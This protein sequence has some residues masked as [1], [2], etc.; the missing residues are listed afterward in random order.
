[1]RHSPGRVVEI[2][3]RNLPPH[4][5]FLLNPNAIHGCRRGLLSVAAPQLEE[6]FESMSNLFAEQKGRWI[7]PAAVNFSRGF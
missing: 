4:P 5:G 6:N 3:P 7:A 1:M 2:I